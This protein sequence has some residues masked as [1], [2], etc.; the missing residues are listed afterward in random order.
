MK[1]SH[2]GW[3]HPLQLSCINGEH[4]LDRFNLTGTVHYAGIN[5]GRFKSNFPQYKLFNYQ[6]NEIICGYHQILL[7]YTFS[8]SVTP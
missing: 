2:Y 4:F 8:C 6:N 5:S 3:V 7:S 1:G